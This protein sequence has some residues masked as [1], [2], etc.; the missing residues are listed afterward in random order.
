MKHGREQYR[1]IIAL[2]AL[3]V[4]ASVPQLKAQLNGHNTRGD[5]GV[6]AGTQPPPG[7]Y[8]VAPLFYRYEADTLRN[9]DGD[10]DGQRLDFSI[11]VNA[12]VFGFLWVSEKKVLGGNYSFQIYP[13]FTDNAL[14][15]PALGVAQGTSTGFTDLYIVPLHL[16]WHRERADFVAGLGIFAPTGRYEAGADDNLGLG[17]W[18]L[19]LFG[20]TTVYLDQGKSWHLATNAYYEFHSEKEGTDVQ[21]GE[22]LTLEGGLGKSFMDGAVMVG[23]AYYAQWKMSR[24]DLGLQF[25]LP[26]GRLPGKHRVFGLG[27]DVTFPIATKKKLIGFVNLRYFWEFDARSTLEGNSLLL[28][29]TFPVPSLSLQ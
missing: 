27:P 21:V 15:A 2:L 17:M 5:F 29:A 28:T 8:V 24:D 4:V 22:L 16:G 10:G 20:G 11:D 18:S 25:V 14:E 12:Y 19:E 9:R 1:R 23:A 7:N 3:A 6:Q 13:G 26:A